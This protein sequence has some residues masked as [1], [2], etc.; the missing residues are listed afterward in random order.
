MFLEIFL[1]NKFWDFQSSDLDSYS[2]LSVCV[3]QNDGVGGGILYSIHN[4][5]LFLPVR[6]RSRIVLPVP[7]VF[8]GHKEIR[9]R[10]SEAKLR[11]LAYSSA[12]ESAFPGAKIQSH[13]M[14]L[15]GNST[16]VAK[17]ESHPEAFQQRIQ[18]R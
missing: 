13:S 10:L 11:L 18:A 5:N 14:C 16:V 9:I 2:S 8:A 1:E 3:Y 15:G 7:L 12:S 4:L 6:C 17:C